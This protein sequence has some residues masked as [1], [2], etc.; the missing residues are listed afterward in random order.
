MKKVIRY[1]VALLVIVGALNWGL[2]G[3]FKFDLVAHLLGGM[4]SDAA[5]AVYGLVGIAGLLALWGLCKCCC[6]CGCSSCG[7]KSGSGCSSS[8]CGGGCKCGNP[9]CN[10]RKGY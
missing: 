10:C 4:H 7:P 5:R 3:F 1:L 9:N 8:G 6:G 2:V